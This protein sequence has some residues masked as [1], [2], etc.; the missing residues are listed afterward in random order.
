MA[1]RLEVAIRPY[2]SSSSMNGM[3][4]PLGRVRQRISGF[5]FVIVLVSCWLVLVE[6][7]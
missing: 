6:L 2:C 3:Q 4:V 7:S 5:G 1:G